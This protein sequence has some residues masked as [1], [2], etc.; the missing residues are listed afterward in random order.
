MRRET[1]F[2]AAGVPAQ[3]AARAVA[4]SAI[5][6]GGFGSANLPCAQLLLDALAE[7]R[8]R[9]L[10]GRVATHERV[11]RALQEVFEDRSLVTCVC[12]RD[13]PRS[14][15]PFRARRRVQIL[16]CAFERITNAFE[17]ITNLF[18]TFQSIQTRRLAR[19]GDGDLGASLAQT[20][21][22]RRRSSKT[23]CRARRTRSCVATRPSRGRS[24]ASASAS[25]RS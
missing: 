25:R 2:R 17:R 13:A 12:A 3:C 23:S 4:T 22:T 10:L 7:A 18:R 19:N 15:S 8:D 11:R 9:L 1:S 5:G 6:D 21:V 14:P 16:Q 20:Q 24:R